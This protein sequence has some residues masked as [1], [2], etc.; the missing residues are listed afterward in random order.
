MRGEGGEQRIVG[1]IEV[2]E[3]EPQRREQR[4]RAI[5][6]G[7]LVSQKYAAKGEIGYRK[8][9]GRE[10]LAAAREG[11]VAQAFLPR[12]ADVPADGNAVLGSAEREGRTRLAHHAIDAVFEG[13][14]PLAIGRWGGGEAGALLEGELAVVRVLPIGRQESIFDR[15]IGAAVVSP[16]ERNALAGVGVAGAQAVDDPHRVRAEGESR[17]KAGEHL[18][19]DGS[20]E[21]FAGQAHAVR[22]IVPD[23]LGEHGAALAVLRIGRGAGRA[24]GVIAPPV[25]ELGKVAAGVGDHRGELA[26]LPRK[27]R[28]L[29]EFIVLAGKL[30]GDE[31]AELRVLDQVDR[32]GGDEADRAGQPVRAVQR[33]GRAAQ[34]L[35]LFDKAHI[36]KPAAPG[37]LRAEVES[38][39]RADAVDLHQHAVA[40]DAADVEAFIAGAPRGSDRRPE[41]CRRAADGDAGFEAHEVLDVGGELVGDVLAGDDS[42]GGWRFL[43]QHRRA[44]GGDGDAAGLLLRFSLGRFGFGFGFGGQVFGSGGDRE[45][46]KGGGAKG[47]S[48]DQRHAG[49]FLLEGGGAPRF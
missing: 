20:I 8:G 4:Q 35:D 24:G 3:I 37:I 46:R 45:Q 10:A 39:R 7:D 42:D 22:A 26:G 48:V 14:E 21:P 11:A 43:L 38:L 2:V 6:Q 27:G 32:I 34:D 49:R 41:A 15:I 13:V 40:A 5:E 9:A 33:R 44:G 31:P 12:P 16:V 47:K 18:G 1:R 29:R 28:G 23:E 19:F 30:R 17:A 36:G 25:F